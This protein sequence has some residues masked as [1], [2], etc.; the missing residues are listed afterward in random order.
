MKSL[1]QYRP[2]Y[3]PARGTVN[4]QTLGGFNINRLYGIINVTRNSILYAPGAVGYGVVSVV[5]G[6]ITL[7][8]NTST[9]AATDTLNVY[10]ETD[11]AQD[12]LAQDLQ[13]QILIELKVMNQ[14]LAQGLNIDNRD[15]D[16]LRAEYTKNNIS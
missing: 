2:Q 12:L 4:F 7:E 3:D 13:Q 14:I 9:H 8:V 15:V 10:Y 6:T 1:L 5:R 11:T 16:N